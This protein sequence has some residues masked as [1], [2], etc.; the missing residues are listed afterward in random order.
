MQ[1]HNT[2]C[3]IVAFGGRD[4]HDIAWAT[5]EGSIELFHWQDTTL[6]E[7]LSLVGTGVQVTSLALS[8]QLPLLASGG[9]CSRRA[10]LQCKSTLP[11][12]CCT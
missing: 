7:T 4:G 10:A 1:A 6:R 12:C 8:H 3:Q 11:A 2:S 9:L 5:S